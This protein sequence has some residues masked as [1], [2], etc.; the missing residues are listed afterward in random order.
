MKKTYISP[1]LEILLLQI[2]DVIT[3]SGLIGGGGG[4]GD[5]ENPG[6]GDDFEFFNLGWDN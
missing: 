6:D 5:I 1:E 4:G 2:S 3:A